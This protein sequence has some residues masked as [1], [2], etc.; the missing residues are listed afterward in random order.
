M[1]QYNLEKLSTTGT[2]A[3][4]PRSGRPPKIAP[5]H[6]AK[7]ERFVRGRSVPSIGTVR[8]ELAHGLDGLP[9]LTVTHKT[10]A[11]HMRTA[12]FRFRKRI[13]KT[14]MSRRT[15]LQ[16]LSFC[17]EQRK[18]SWLQWIFSDES[19]VNRGGTTVGE[20]TAPGE[21]PRLQLEANPRGGVT[22]WGAVSWWGKSDLYIVPSKWTGIDYVRFFRDHGFAAVKSLAEKSRAWEFKFQQDNAPGHRA[23]EFTQYAAEVGLPLVK[24][25]PTSSDLS[26]IEEVW[27]TLKRNVEMRRARSEEEL[28]QVI[29]DEWNKITLEEIRSH[30]IHCRDKLLKCIAA[31]GYSFIE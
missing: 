9:P 31:G 18:K 12:K 10:M 5:Q 21:E 19:G 13:R 17:D 3:D 8:R 23:K 16:R 29:M 24:W 30:I 27:S 25:P 28:K 26:P 7:V 22:V 11:K 20:W 6:L 1:I 2:L 4:R 14:L 15:A